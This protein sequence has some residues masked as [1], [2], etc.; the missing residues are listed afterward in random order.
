MEISITYLV[1]VFG[2]GWVPM[3]T[4][5]LSNNTKIGVNS[6]WLF[7]VQWYTAYNVIEML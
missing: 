6:A 7:G 5:F 2:H 4:I 1:N 3:R